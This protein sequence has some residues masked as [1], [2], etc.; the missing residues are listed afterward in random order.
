MRK[1]TKVKPN[2]PE[3]RGTTLETGVVPIQRRKKANRGELE[4][5]E[6]KMTLAQRREDDSIAW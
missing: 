5:G 4:I 1:L 2:L 6:E 3:G